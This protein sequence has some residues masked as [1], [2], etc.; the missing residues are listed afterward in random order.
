MKKN[1]LRGWELWDIIKHSNIHKTG[2][3]QKKKEQSKI[4][5][6]IMTETSQIWWK[7]L[8]YISQLFNQV[9]VQ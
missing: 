1:E 7:A 9:Q 8:T 2:V 6:K 3:C 5:F 4:F